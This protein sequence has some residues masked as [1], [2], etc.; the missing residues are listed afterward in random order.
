MLTI[1]KNQ[2]KILLLFLVIFTSAI[3]HAKPNE[4]KIQLD[5]FNGGSYGTNATYQLQSS[6]GQPVPQKIKS[7]ELY[8]F[9]EGFLFP[10]NVAPE[11]H[12]QYIE[13][14]EDT[15]TDIILTATDVDPTN[16]E[17]SYEIVEQASHGDLSGVTPELKYI[18]H[19]NFFGTDS[20]TFKVNDGML[21]SETVIVTIKSYS[22]NDRPSLNLTS[23]E[24]QLTEDF[25]TYTVPLTDISS[26][27][28]NEQQPLS[29]TAISSNPE[30]INSFTIDYQ[31]PNKT[32]LLSF[33]PIPDA[34][35]EVSITVTVNDHGRLNNT[36]SYLLSVFVEPVN[37][38]PDF[39][40]GENV[41]AFEDNG[42]QTFF[43]WA[44][45]ISP[46]PQDEADQVVTFYVSNDN[47]SLFKKVPDISSDGTL[48][49]TPS[50]NSYGI[51]NVS[52]YIEDNGTINRTRTKNARL[53][54]ITIKPVNDP[55]SFITGPNQTVLEDSPL[56]IISGWANHIMAGPVNESIQELHFIV[57][58]DNL[59]LFKKAPEISPDG[60]LSYEPEQ[61]ESGIARLE[62]NLMDN[63][64]IEHGGNNKSYTQITTIEILPVNDKPSFSMGMDITV[65]EDC[66][67]QS[68]EN[69]ASH[70]SP[71]PENESHQDQVF[72]LT[73]TVIHV[74]S[75]QLFEQE[76][77]ISK[78]GTLEFKPAKDAFG[79][80][81]VSVF[82]K[83]DG[84][85][86]NYGND[87]TSTQ[88]F[89]ISITPVPDSP[90][91]KDKKVIAYE[92]KSLTIT[93]NAFDPDDDT[94][95][96]T[97]DQ[98]PKHGSLTGRG[99]VTIYQPSPD[100][101]GTDSFTFHVHDQ[102]F[103]SNTATVTIH[104]EAGVNPRIDPIQ[105]QE[106]NEDVSTEPVMI[107]LM[108]AQGGIVS[109]SSHS[110]N[111][112][113]VA[114]EN[115]Y[116]SDN[117]IHLTEG[118]SACLS[119]TIIPE[120]NQFG[121]ADIV[122]TATDSQGNTGTSI[123]TIH[124]LPV[125]DCPAFTPGM[126]QVLIE[127]A[128][129]QS[130]TNWAKN[131]STGPENEAHQTLSFKV[132][133][134]YPEL[135]VESP[136][137]TTDGT[138]I[139]KPSP[140]KY[141]QSTVKVVLQ[142]NGNIDHNGCN[143][144]FEK[145][146]SI[147]VRSKN[148]PPFFTK[149]SDQ[150]INEDAGQKTILYWARNIASGPE[151]ESDQFI[152]FFVNTDKPELFIEN[153]VISTDG[154]LSWE[155]YPN[156]NGF[157]NVN[158]FLKD[159]GGTQNGGTDVS[160]IQSFQI[161][162]H[163]VNDPP[164][165]TKGEDQ[166]ILENSPLQTIKSW[167]SHIIPGLADELAQSVIFRVSTNNDNL[168]SIL[169]KITS[170]G[171]LTFQPGQN[172]TGSALVTVFLEDNGGTT[173]GGDNTSER[174]SFKINITPVYTLSVSLAETGNCGGQLKTEDGVLH[175]FDWSENFP[176]NTLVSL[177]ALPFSTC[178][179]SYWSG[180]TVD[181]GHTI[182]IKMDQ[183][184]HLTANFVDIPLYDLNISNPTRETQVF[185]NDLLCADEYCHYTFLE[186]DSVTITA[187]PLSRFVCW[188]G[189]VT[190]TSENSII[191]EMNDHKNVFANF[192]NWAT[193]IYLE[194][195][196]SEALDA[197]YIT[198]GAAS[199]AYT[200]IVDP[201][202]S[203]H[204]GAIHILS[205]DHQ[206]WLA[207]DFRD[208]NDNTS[209][210]IIGVNPKA[211]LDI[212]NETGVVTINW[213]PV[214]FSDDSCYELRQGL[215]QTGEIL[216]PDMRTKTQ[217]TIT[218]NNAYQYFTIHRKSRCAWT[219]TIHAEGE[220]FQVQN[221]SDVKIGVAHEES[222]NQA[223]SPAPEYTSY[224]VLTH[225]DEAKRK[226][227][228]QFCNDSYLW[229]INV[230]ASGN[231]GS[232]G[233]DKRCKISWNPEEFAPTGYYRLI[234]GSQTS[235]E[236]VVS[237]MRKTNTFDVTGG[238][239]FQTFTIIWS[240][241]F[242]VDIEL[243][244]DYNLIS[245]P[246]SPE[247]SDLQSLFPGA[248]VAYAFENYGYVEVTKL[249][250][251]KGYFIEMPSQGI[252]RIFG[253]PF[254]GYTNTLPLGWSLMGAALEPALTPTSK[255]YQPEMDDCIKVMYT[256]DNGRYI[257]VT[258]FDPG[259]GYWV[260]VYDTDACEVSVDIFHK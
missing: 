240:H 25:D 183:D 207:R 39:T 109:V 59:S 52:V 31:S 232:P 63:G 32:G 101:Y 24:I 48:T 169:P 235:G 162:V 47:N 122:L 176:E 37:D 219:A 34:K 92:N 254:P 148:D 20:F 112:E 121:S 231:V 227:I 258:A 95:G 190:E 17:L 204:T 56:Q 55:P 195:Q 28:S 187:E 234:K 58:T 74:N 158:V 250:P 30:I 19:N 126:N 104:V 251:S 21:D 89:H 18:P 145:E 138:L 72:Y 246:L 46:G 228:Y 252:Y 249:E 143:Q 73:T 218:G 67:Y 147:T 68:I 253:K 139:Y 159:S 110:L 178:Y 79:A 165:F 163:P 257:R 214:N 127:D 164:S 179:F 115:I 212:S 65:T 185:I 194:P 9:N 26:G 23:D 205:S 132:T 211:S 91:A 225:N 43:E 96:Y 160:T 161:N 149:G 27:A 90:I 230:N 61:N 224:M 103:I 84:G 186:H 125:N 38:P 236:L 86:E 107:N 170:Q 22:V 6:F 180:I 154:H 75:N 247:Q 70:I 131:M 223:L 113:L 71:G 100:F 116:L 188:T 54:T 128:G 15:P 137:I 29:I 82:L 49:F 260:N 93:L 157:A 76:P 51:A 105:A 123:F 106:T 177:E 14:Y 172:K 44:K 191:V 99:P 174:Q 210:W 166:N 152:Q 40:P 7:N 42:E 85:T 114:D 242:W 239:E 120:D 203:I 208:M 237:D 196:S 94:L 142:D 33:V 255:S 64:G 77:V 202:S 1:T 136:F 222:S 197:P 243:K 97:I 226:V 60:S 16:I 155:T 168:F 213:D 175:D 129:Q 220:N 215:N 87:Q 66:E 57:N 134:D 156:A 80:A 184:I 98:L 216:I 119:L 201:V 181:S 133:A 209:V 3:V 12:S 241:H 150:T 144:S 238:N 45:N 124:V 4:I 50:S 62:I 83:D 78:T 167:A 81:S 192:N 146:F 102:K 171:E 13:T 5:S 111:T 217:Y 182:S 41:D 248:L 108:D 151:N 189:D 130:I 118:V 233:I 140:D 229:T 153:P 200:E 221:K 69:W 256:F 198:I 135:F 88:I 173:N 53:F 11:A 206:S 2:K 141:G 259:F 245:L 244:K 10:T 199:M 35:G 117:S 36:Q 193:S 8:V